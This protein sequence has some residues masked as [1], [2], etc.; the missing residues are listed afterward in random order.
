[1][2]IPVIGYSCHS[3]ELCDEESQILACT[4]FQLSM[5]ILKLG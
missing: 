4:P 1:M 3:E 2:S 5:T